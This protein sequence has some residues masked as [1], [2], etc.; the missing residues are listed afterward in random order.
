MT[1]HIRGSAPPAERSAGGPLD[2]LRTLIQALPVPTAPLTFPSRDA[3]L[4]LALM[5]LSLRL[6]HLARLS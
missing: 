5:D 2:H 6:D 4:G 1:V 3:A